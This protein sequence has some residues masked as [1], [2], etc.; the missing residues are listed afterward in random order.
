MTSKSDLNNKSVMIIGGG[1]AGMAAA[2]TL[3][4]NGTKVHIV[5]KDNHIGGHAA[6]WACMATETCQHCSTCLTHEMASKIPTNTNVHLNS[7]VIKIDKNKNIYTAHL[8]NNNS[9]IESD[10]IILATG[11]KQK[12]P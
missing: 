10:R 12:N 5:E 7:K 9:I 3:S 6:S 2:E 4:K 1:V 11:F 8:N